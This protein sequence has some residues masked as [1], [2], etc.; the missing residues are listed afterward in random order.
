MIAFSGWLV[1]SHL[2][3]TGYACV[4]DG[5]V[6]QGFEDDPVVKTGLNVFTVGILGLAVSVVMAV[7][8]NWSPINKIGFP[9]LW[10][11]TR[12]AYNDRSLHYRP[13][14]FLV[15][16]KVLWERSGPLIPL[17]QGMVH[18]SRP[19]SHR[20]F[21]F[22]ENFVIQETCLNI[23]DRLVFLYSITSIIKNVNIGR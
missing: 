1:L 2:V 12:I 10:R 17:L 4:K 5:E 20:T 6:R 23:A 9:V 8:L 15:K 7:I 11:N 16:F 18:K 13:E 14:I 22:I 19:T 21:F 3:M